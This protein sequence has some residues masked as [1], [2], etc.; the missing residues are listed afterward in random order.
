MIGNVLK[1]LAKSLLILLGLTAAASATDTA[2]H[3]KMFGS[4]FT[5][6][7]VFNGEMEDIMKMVKSLEESGLLIKGVSETIQNEA[8]EQKGGILSML[9]STLDA[10]FS[11][12]LVTVTGTIRAGEG[13]I[14]AGENFKCHP[15]L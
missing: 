6:L 2:I 14:R 3:K 11:G 12:N 1:P 5:T 8:K 7:I 4:G 15:I 10:S 13:T 9:L